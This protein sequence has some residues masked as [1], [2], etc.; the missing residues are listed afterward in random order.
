VS[1]K[2]HAD[3]VAWQGRGLK[4]GE[5]VGGAEQLQTMALSGNVGLDNAAV[6]GPVC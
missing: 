3:G 1:H 2:R 6:V 5:W 4:R